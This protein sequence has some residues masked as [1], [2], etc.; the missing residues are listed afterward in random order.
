MDSINENPTYTNGGKLKIK[1]LCVS[2]LKTG[3]EKTHHRSKILQIDTEDTEKNLEKIASLLLCDL[4]A[5]AGKSLLFFIL[6]GAAPI[7]KTSPVGAPLVGALSPEISFSSLKIS[8][9]LLCDLCA[10]AVKS[11][12]FFILPDAAPSPAQ[13]PSLVSFAALDRQREFFIYVFGGF[14]KPPKTW[15]FLSL[16]H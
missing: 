1:N 16:S 3:P 7:R 10:S 8:S 4:C 2:I 5:S 12:L 11:L 9:L 6:R 15:P 14:R 13:G